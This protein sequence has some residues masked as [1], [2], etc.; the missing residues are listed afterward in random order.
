MRA[1]AVFGF[2]VLFSI[3]ALGHHATAAQYDVSTTMTLKGTVGRVEWTNPHIHVVVDVKLEDG[4]SEAWTVEFPAPGA[5]IVAG[6]SKQLLAPG[7]GITLEAYPAKSA[8]RSA[9]AKAM[10]LPDGSRVTFVVGI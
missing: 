7:K 5:A 8:R 10:T 9:C 2:L 6:L 3:G 4:N 1:I